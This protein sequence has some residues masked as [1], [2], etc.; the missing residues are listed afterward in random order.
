MLKIPLMCSREI[1]TLNSGR[2]VQVKMVPFSFKEY[3]VDFVAQNSK[4]TVY[5]QVALS[6]RDESTLERVL[7][8]LRAI[9][10]HYP[11]VLLTIDKDAEAHYDGIQ[12]INERDWLLDLTE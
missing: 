5:Y 9:C 10:D 11:K 12:R 3:E 1:A 7:R 4:G 8:P 6:T 2:Y